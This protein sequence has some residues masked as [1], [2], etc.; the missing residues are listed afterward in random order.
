MSS[1]STIPEARTNVPL[2][3]AF[4]DVSGYSRA[5]AGRADEELAAFADELYAA[6]DRHVQG[7]GGRVVKHVGD[8]SLLAWP[9]S[10]ADPAA[11]ALLALREDVNRLLKKRGW[12]SELVV[13]VHVSDVV[14]G[15][16]GAAGR[17]DV[18]GHGVMI[19][20]RLE[21]RTISFSQAAFRALGPEMRALLKKHTPPVVYVPANDPR[22]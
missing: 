22:P 14:A 4:T 21:A 17:F 5:A 15:P 2:V 13:R 11:K 10:E 9:A 12:N 6:T 1:S 3:I 7:A 19:A 20:A 18:I 8:G 16:F